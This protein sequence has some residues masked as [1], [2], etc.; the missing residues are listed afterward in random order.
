MSSSSSIHPRSSYQIEFLQRSHER[1]AS[2]AQYQENFIC[3]SPWCQMYDENIVLPTLTLSRSHA[4]TRHTLS[5]YI[6]LVCIRC[7]ETE[8]RMIYY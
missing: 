3:S 2:I 1:L 6:L 4:I 8:G 7:G 5:E